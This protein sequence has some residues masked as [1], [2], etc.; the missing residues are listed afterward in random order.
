MPLCYGHPGQTHLRVDLLIGGHAS[1]N[2]CP[3]ESGTFDCRP[4][5]QQQHIYRCYFI[6]DL[7]DYGA[8]SA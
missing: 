7:F 3:P 8:C 4:C 6:L 5:L 1:N 2:T